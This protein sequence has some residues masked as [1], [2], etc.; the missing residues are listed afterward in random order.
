M[1][2]YNKECNM[3]YHANSA[4]T[5]DVLFHCYEDKGFKESENIYVGET[6]FSFVIRSN[7]G[8]GNASYLQFRA[9]YNTC[10]LYDYEAG[11]QKKI[12]YQSL[13]L[14]PIQTIGISS[15]VR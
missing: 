13:S 10:K 6:G 15:F 12:G 9:I 7:F 8:Y 1:L 4:P 3:L 5:A 11:Y 14:N 2:C